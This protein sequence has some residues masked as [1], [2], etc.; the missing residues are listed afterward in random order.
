MLTCF[1]AMLLAVGVSFGCGVKGIPA[2]TPELS[3]RVCY[4]GSCLEA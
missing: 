4:G 2:L 1:D 3:D